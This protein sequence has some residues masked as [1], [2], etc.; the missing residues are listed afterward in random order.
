[1]KSAVIGFPVRTTRKPVQYVKICSLYGAGFYYIPGTDTCLKVGGYV[2][3]EMNFNAN[4]SYNPYRAVNFDS[5]ATNREVSRV[6]FGI[7][8]DA[9]SQTEYG[10]LRSYAFFAS[11]MTNGG[12]GNNAAPWNAFGGAPYNPIY[13][14]AGFI[15]FAGFTA[16]ATTSFFDFDT[17]PYSNQTNFWGNNQ[18][19]N[20]VPLFAYTATFGNGFSATLSAED[21]ANR[22]SAL[23]AP[24]AQLLSVAA[25]GRTSSAPCAST[26]LGAAFSC[27]A[28]STKK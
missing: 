21:T 27:L 28:P 25:N 3:A 24:L 20:G 23:E 14:P 17:Q 2:R 5:P 26:R 13:A 18:S 16:G 22:T 6:R 1:M 19:G 15:Q 12:T 9:R 4:G 10:T 8:L 7:S 11:T